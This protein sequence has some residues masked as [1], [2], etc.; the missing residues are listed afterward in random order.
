MKKRSDRLSRIAHLRELTRQRH[1]RNLGRDLRSLADAEA[2]H[3][4]LRDYQANYGVQEG[5]SLNGSA[6]G[7]R[8]AFLQSISR[9]VTQQEEQVRQGAARV[10]MSR[11]QW[12][13]AW[14]A[15]N[16][17]DQWVSRVAKQERESTERH[18][19]NLSEDLLS[20]RNRKV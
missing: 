16:V 19:Q 9:A 13:E 4:M 17:M 5:K 6:L 10:R 7:N 2:Q 12:I 1:E 14:Q 15:S 8:R 18:Q 20:T 3:Q 11:K